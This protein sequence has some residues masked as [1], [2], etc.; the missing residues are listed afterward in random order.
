MYKQF[1]VVYVCCL[2]QNL[3]CMHCTCTYYIRSKA[4]ALTGPGDFIKLFLTEAFLLSVCIAT[5]A[6]AE[7]VIGLG[8]NKSYAVDGRW[9]RLSVE[10]LTRYI[11]YVPT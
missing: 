9:E 3:E 8:Q 7:S 4:D 6:Y 1:L 11:C 5:N 10:E 2:S